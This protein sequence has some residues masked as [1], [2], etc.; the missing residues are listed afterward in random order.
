MIRKSVLLIA[1]QYFGYDSLIAQFMRSN[2]IDVDLLPDRPLNSNAGKAVMRLNR[3]LAMP[4]ADR[5]FKSR[6]SSL[7]RKRYDAI[8]VIQGEGLSPDLLKW[9]RAAYSATPLIW[10][11]WDSFENK[12]ALRE[13]L[14]Y[15][16]TVFTFDPKDAN[17]YGMTLQPLFFAPSWGKIVHAKK[18]YDL[19]F[20][21]TGHEDRFPLVQS[22]KQSHSDKNFFSFLFLPSPMLY[23]WRRLSEKNFRGSTPGDFSFDKMTLAEIQGIVAQSQ[24]VLDIQHPAQRGLTMRTV[25]TMGARKKLVTTN[26]SVRE[27]DFYNENNVLVIDRKRPVIPESFFQTEYRPIA[28]DVMEKYSVLGFLK[29]LLGSELFCDKSA[30]RKAAQL[31]GEVEFT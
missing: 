4:L 20:I 13:N 2:G 23:A 19:C 29:S 16:D 12:P 3:N 7:E 24:V 21:G 18:K 26:V 31:V 10:Y 30:E 22:L 11:L 9:V 6:V 28:A 5:Y 8:L 17:D 27:Y 25:E 1:P 14:P 15:F